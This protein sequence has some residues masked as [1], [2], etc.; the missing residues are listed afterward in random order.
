MPYRISE[1]EACSASF[2]RDTRTAIINRM[3]VAEA[4]VVQKSKGR[5]RNTIV[6]RTA[7]STSESVA[8]LKSERK[9][10]YRG[11]G[12]NVLIAVF[13]SPIGMMIGRLTPALR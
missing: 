4:S 10:F 11:Y 13:T 3:I 7:A 12:A 6:Q 1:I 8:S 9:V 2:S 5:I